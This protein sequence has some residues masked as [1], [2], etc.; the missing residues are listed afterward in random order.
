MLKIK[1]LENNLW[2]FKKLIFVIKFYII[3]I[4]DKKIKQKVFAKI[5]NKKQ[6]FVNFSKLFKNE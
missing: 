1:E 5:L 2:F 4:T 3:L 6:L